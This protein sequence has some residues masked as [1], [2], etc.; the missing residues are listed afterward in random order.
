LSFVLTS[1]PNPNPNCNAT[2]MTTN[3]NTFSKIQARQ[4]IIDSARETA[5]TAIKMTRMGED[6]THCAAADYL[7]SHAFDELHH[8][9][10]HGNFGL[11]SHMMILDAMAEFRTACYELFGSLRKSQIDVISRDVE[12]AINGLY[13]HSTKINNEWLLAY[14]QW[15]DFCLDEVS[16]FVQER[17]M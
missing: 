10:K 11:G 12:K 7:A 13:K 4:R 3:T 2:T 16:T 6:A 8:A 15:L 1:N 14:A 9:A 17:N 5:T